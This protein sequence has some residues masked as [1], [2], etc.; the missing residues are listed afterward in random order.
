MVQRI[1]RI[2]ISVERYIPFSGVSTFEFEYV[3]TR[4]DDP[5]VAAVEEK[6]QQHAEAL[7]LALNQDPPANLLG[8]L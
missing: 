1:N 3:P 4:D 5:F 8:L 2:H 7:Q 6:I